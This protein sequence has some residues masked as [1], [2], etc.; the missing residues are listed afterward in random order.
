MRGNGF[1]V[2]VSPLKDL[3][4]RIRNLDHTWL[5]VRNVSIDET[6]DE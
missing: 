3:V 1:R 4:M 2:K 5:P 6:S